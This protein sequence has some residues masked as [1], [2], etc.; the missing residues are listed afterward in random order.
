VLK[1]SAWLV[2]YNNGF[3]GTMRENPAFAVWNQQ[4]YLQRYPSPPRNSQPLTDEDAARCGFRFAHREEYTNDVQ[5]SPEHLAAYLTTQSNVIAAVEQGSESETEIYAWLIE[6]LT[7]LF[8][9]PRGT[10]P[11]GGAIW[12]LEKA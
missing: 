3:Y 12:Y 7:P 8:P 5:F 2:I 10:F 4:H 9:E 11:F 1:P 6:S